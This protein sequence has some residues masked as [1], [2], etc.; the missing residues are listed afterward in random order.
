MAEGHLE[1]CEPREALTRALVGA[2]AAASAQEV[3]L[4]ALIT[5]HCPRP[6]LISPP[7]PCPAQQLRSRLSYVSNAGRNASVLT[8]WPSALWLKAPRIHLSNPSVSLSTP[9]LSKAPKLQVWDSVLGPPS[10][11]C[12]PSLGQ[13]PHSRQWS[14]PGL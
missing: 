11:L 8:L 6:H 3:L 7:G 12:P 2:V 10:H 14:Q 4:T 13:L 9:L 1:G 5:S